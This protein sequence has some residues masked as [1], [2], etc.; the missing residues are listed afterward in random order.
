MAGELVVKVECCAVC[1]SD[2]RIFENGNPRVIFP[3]IMGHEIAGEIIE[4]GTGVTK[5]SE[6]ERVSLGADV[7]CG[8]CQWCK[9]GLGNNCKKNLA[10][11]YQMNGGFA[12][13]I[14]LDETVVKYG[15][16][17][18]LP[19]HTSFEEG[20]LAEP[21]ACC[22]NGMEVTGMKKGKSV[23][24][25]GAGPVGCMLAMLA[26]ALGA[27]KTILADISSERLNASKV[28]DANHYFNSI[29]SAAFEESVLNATNGEGVDV[30]FTACPSPEAQE[31]STRLLRNKGTVNFFGGLPQG[32]KKISLDSNALHYRELTV[33]GSHG[34]V[35]RQHAQAVEL[36][37][38]KKIDVGKLVSK[39]YPLDEINSAFADLRDKKILKAV[40]KPWR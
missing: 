2:L 32:S 30:V 34:S 22:I 8:E 37:S 23:L 29:D 10:I 11:G 38:S 17:A 5:F 7:P 1:G 21:L 18:V 20:C 19:A 13:Y 24:V 6:G 35:P 28:A 4:V 15:P 27:S 14:R 40:I 9:N 3:R 39:T 16:I 33:T 12:E 26:K 25:I 31:A 36:I